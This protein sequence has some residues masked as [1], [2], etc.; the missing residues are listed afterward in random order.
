MD[1]PVAPLAVA[2]V[3]AAAVCQVS[4]VVELHAGRS[5]DVATY[6]TEGRQEGVKV[7]ADDGSSHI[8][9]HIVARFGERL[10]HLAERVRGAV[11]TALAAEIGDLTDVTIDVHVADVTDAGAGAAGDDEPAGQAAIGSG[12]GSA[13]GGGQP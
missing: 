7:R 13:V 5:G 1:L 10:D 3:V 12:S 8:T 4:G 11:S 9:V 2:R 6:G